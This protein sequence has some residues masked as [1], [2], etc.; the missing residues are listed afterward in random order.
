MATIDKLDL[1]VYIQYARRTQYIEEVTREYGLDKA[2]TIPPQTTITDLAP[3]LS[4]LDMLLGVYRSYSPWA[5]FLPP[6]KFRFQRRSPFTKSRV[7]PSITMDE[8]EGESFFESI[9][10]DS[11]E[12][13]EEKEVLQKCLKQLSTINEWLGYIIGRVGQLLQG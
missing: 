10:T 4:E 5:Y 9:Q 8:E 3:K 12:E 7:S 2:S 13:E 6:K 1:G 11:P